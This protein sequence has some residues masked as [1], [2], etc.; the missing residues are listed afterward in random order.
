[1]SCEGSTTL[2]PMDEQN[3][4][5]ELGTQP[6]HNKMRVNSG[7]VGPGP[8]SPIIALNGPLYIAYLQ[9]LGQTRD[10]FLVFIHRNQ[11]TKLPELHS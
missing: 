8:M 11:Q 2:I 5:R 10:V 9:Q 7:S 4:G 6:G 3:S 1:M